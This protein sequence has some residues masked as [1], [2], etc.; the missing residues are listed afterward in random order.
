MT[1]PGSN[2]TGEPRG[3]VGRQQRRS[4]RAPH[5]APN[6]PSIV[7]PASAACS[8]TV[9]LRVLPPRRAAEASGE[10]FQ[11]EVPAEG[12]RPPSSDVLSPPKAEHARVRPECGGWRPNWLNSLTQRPGWPFRRGLRTFRGRCRVRHLR[13]SAGNAGLRRQPAMLGG[14]ILGVGLRRARTSTR[15]TVYV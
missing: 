1:R 8:G 2:V 6:S 10:R 9:R 11:L 3:V 7:T 15:S 5:R 4:P 12:R 14:K 13:V